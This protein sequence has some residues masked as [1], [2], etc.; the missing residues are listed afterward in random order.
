MSTAAAKSSGRKKRPGGRGPIKGF[1]RSVIHWRSGKRIYPKTAKAFP[2]R[3][4]KRPPVSAAV[5]PAP[6]TPTP[7]LPA[8]ANPAQVEQAQPEQ[9]PLPFPAESDV[10]SAV[11]KAK[12]GS[13]P[14]RPRQK[15]PRT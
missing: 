12:R 2:L 14:R 1:A 10:V 15:T 7:P 6:P 4:R 3:G 5:V 11:R 13:T 8:R 9:M